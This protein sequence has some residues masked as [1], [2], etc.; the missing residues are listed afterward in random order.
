MDGDEGAFVQLNWGETAFTCPQFPSLC[1][2]LCST[3]DKVKW[4]QKRLRNVF[5]YLFNCRIIL[6]YII[7]ICLAEFLGSILEE[8][9]VLDVPSVDHKYCSR[10]GWKNVLFLDQFLPITKRVKMIF[11]LFK[12][13][14]LITTSS[15]SPSVCPLDVVRVRWV[16]LRCLSP[17]DNNA[18]Q[19]YS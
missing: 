5:I 7:I 10:S 16:L 4:Y 18:D 11:S 1:G 2:G 15:S 13:I 17:V 9:A 6:P 19:T 3:I 8:W 12:S 14:N